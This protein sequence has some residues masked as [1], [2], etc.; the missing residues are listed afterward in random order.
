M[1]SAITIILIFS[2]LFQLFAAGY[3]IYLIKYTGFKY[4]WIFLSCALILMSIRRAI[5]LYY[6]VSDLKYNINFTSELLGLILSILILFGIIGIGRILLERMLAEEKINSLLNEKEIILREV[7]HRIKNNLNT[8]HNLLMLQVESSEN[9]EIKKA[10]DNAASRVRAMLSLYEELFVSGHYTEVNLK[11]YLPF[12][13]ERIIANFPDR[14][15]IKLSVQSQEI[16]LGEKNIA[17]LNLII[18]ELLTNIMKYAFTG[19]EEG[20]ISVELKNFDNMVLL[21]VQDDGNGIP[22]NIDLR[23]SNGFGLSLVN[24]LTR[25][26][27]GTISFESNNGTKVN[28]QFPL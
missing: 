20:K 21:S 12:L 5:P 27:D 26:L 1:E 13:C 18:N 8:T 4:S 24:M 22:D 14:N 6:L 7:H 3:S 23:N 11:D 2:I 25:Q 10:L 19:K 28:L 16:S 17:S 9:E 15:K